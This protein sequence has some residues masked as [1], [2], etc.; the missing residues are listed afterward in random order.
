MS[1]HDYNLKKKI[2]GITLAVH[3]IHFYSRIAVY[4]DYL[5]GK[6]KHIYTQCR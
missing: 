3:T 6:I 2:M 1:C 5:G 4:L